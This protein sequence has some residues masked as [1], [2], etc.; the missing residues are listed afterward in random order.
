LA[1]D[2]ADF[3]RN[4]I[5]KIRESFPPANASAH[6]ADHVSA[7]SF[8][9]LEPTCEEEIRKIIMSS[10]SKS[11]SLDP[12][13]T[14]LLKQCLDCLLPI[15]VSIVNTS[16][17]SCQ[18]PDA[19]KHAIVVPL[20]KKVSLDCENKKN[21][22][23]V[24][25]L[26]FLGKLIEKIAI[27]RCKGH[28]KLNG[29]D[30]PLQSAYK[31][32]HSVETALIKCFD[33]FL[34]AVDNGK[35]VMVSLL[36]FSAA[37]DTIDHDVLYRR[38]KDS[39][40]VTGDA[41]DWVK[42]YFSNR[43]QA[44]NI[45]GNISPPLSLDYGMPQGSVFGPFSFPKYS[46]PIAQI[47]IKHGVLYH[48]YADDTQMY[49]VFDVDSQDNN[50]IQLER[51]I[52]EVRE[53]ATRN[54]LK[55]NDSKTEFLVLTSRHSRQTPN[56]SS[57]NVGGSN[58]S[59]VHSA[60]NIGAVMDDK[61]T[62]VDHVSAIC[63]SSYAHL[64]SIAQIRRYLTQDATACLIHAFVTSKLDNMNSLLIGLPDHMIKK[65]QY[66]QNHAAKIVTRKKKYDHVSP[67]LQSLHWLPVYF[68][69]QYKVLLMTH[70][71]LHGKAPT[72]LA[73]LL[74]RYVPGRSLRSGDQ[75][76]LVEKRSKLKTY[77]DRAFS[78]AAP[79]LWNALPLELRKCECLNSFKS[80]LKTVLFKQAFK[81]I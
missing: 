38:L 6:Y 41:L 66:I 60:R 54:M 21:Y 64:R 9:S 2:F 11:C 68:R 63:K 40:G 80:S 49:V 51:C 56:V 53:W 55:L 46:S 65:L 70:K 78:V 22:R 13:P 36:D 73:A 52:S 29:L 28:M 20:L 34:C 30:E 72:Y 31:E 37:F 33:D 67:L 79:R 12:I 42:S 58:V 71:C 47:A 14:S 76:L 69:I 44:V 26:P 15:L 81:L 8:S 25:N 61:L 39:Y 7:P 35:C 27:A 18:F 43:S 17:S 23:P 45:N 3:F 5:S 62:M 50:K 1:G 4:K 48:L 32:L 19:L 10:N 75:Y 77:G 59:A 16:F 74:E 24:S 57:I